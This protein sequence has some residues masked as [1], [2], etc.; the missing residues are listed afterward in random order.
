M[1]EQQQYALYR[2]R[3]CLRLLEVIRRFGVI[4]HKDGKSSVIPK[5]FN[6]MPIHFIKIKIMFTAEKSRLFFNDPKFQ[7]IE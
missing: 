3:I 7:E 1:V 2:T 4:F 6:D 5:P